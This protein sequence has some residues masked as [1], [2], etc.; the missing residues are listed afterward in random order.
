MP[1]KATPYPDQKLL[2]FKRQRTFRGRNLLQIALPLGGIGAGCVSLNGQGGLQ[3]FAIRHNPAISA[4]PDG[5]NPVDCAFGAIYLPDTGIARML[6]GPMP[7]ERI[8]DQG[9]KGQGFREGGHE[10]LP[11]FRAST[12]R[13]EYPFGYV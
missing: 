10:G 7:V 9:L 6:E 5:H 8:Y 13:G 2:T 12:F 11:R 3:D 4:A 1:A